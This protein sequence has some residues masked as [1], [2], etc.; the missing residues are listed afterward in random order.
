M[1]LICIAGNIG[2]GKSTY[3]KKL[4]ESLPPKSGHFEADMFFMENGKYKFDGSKIKNAHAWCKANVESYLIQNID[5]I[6]SNTFTQLWEVQ[7]Y[8]DLAKKY[9][10]EVIIYKMTKNYGNIHDIPDEVYDR[11]KTRLE[12]LP[13]EILVE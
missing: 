9:N 4:L 6:V 7:P 8:L 2:S 12:P 13:N 5:V 11:M 3:A 1:K 10:A